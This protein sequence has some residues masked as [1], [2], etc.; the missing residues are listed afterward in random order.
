MDDGPLQ[1]NGEV[2]AHVFDARGRQAVE[3]HRVLGGVVAGLDCRI[4]FQQ[5]EAAGNDLLP[6][7][8][9]L[10]IE[11]DL[12]GGGAHAAQPVVAAGLGEVVEDV[13]EGDPVLAGEPLQDR[14]LECLD[15]S[16]LPVEPLG[17][18]VAE[19]GWAAAALQLLE[20]RDALGV[21]DDVA[22]VWAGGLG[23]E[24]AALDRPVERSSRE[25]RPG[26]ADE[27]RREK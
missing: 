13:D 27:E 21:R 19:L 5:A 26:E 2:V 8:C 20:E 24:L 16:P 10:A 3:A 7:H 6:S 15:G 12:G 23:V 25:G 14:F 18:R 22:E 11:P 1:A 17:D 9:R 4:H